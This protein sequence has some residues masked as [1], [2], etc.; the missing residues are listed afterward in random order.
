M[1]PRVFARGGKNVQQPRRPSRIGELTVSAELFN[2]STCPACGHHVAV[3]FFDGGAQALATIA[4]PASTKEAQAMPKLPLSFVRCVECGHVYNKDFEYAHVPY[5][6][7]PNLMFNRGFIWNEHLRRVRDLILADLPAKPVVVEIGCGEGHLLRALAE[8]RPDGRYIGFDP[9]GD[10]DTADGRME[11]RKEL[12]DPAIHLNE[13]RPNMVVS[14]HVL[15][16]LINPLGFLQRL[17]FAARWLAMETSLFIEVPCIDRAF[18][19]GRIAD[20]YYEHN[21]HFTT[22][23]FSRMLNNCNANVKM[24]E[25]GYNGEVILGLVK[26]GGRGEKL[27]YAQQALDFSARA[28][29]AK[30]TIGTQLAELHR[31]GKRVAIWGGTGKGAAFIN[32]YGADAERFPLVVDSDRDKV[33]TFVPGTGQEILFRDV[34]LERP[35]DVVII[36]TQWRAKDI[37]A[38]MARAGI[39]SQTLLIEHHGRLADYLNETHPYK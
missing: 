28:T 10:V 1:Y 34:L 38:E 5:S 27:E 15:E 21:S 35:A 22:A 18:E 23:S 20:F 33:G 19:T 16:H 37:V 17:V 9:N 36:P 12:F 13:C 26:L 6:E 32:Y 4:W 39:R 2:T 3:A 7:K 14:R 29:Q 30:H 25:H 24:I 11:A 8:A 31:S